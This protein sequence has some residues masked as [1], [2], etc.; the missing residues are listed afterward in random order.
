MPKFEPIS[1][2]SVV[3]PVYNE[4]DN[5]VPL[6]EEIYSVLRGRAFEIVYVDDQSVDDTWLVLNGA[7][8]RFPRL[9]PLRH[10]Q[11][12]GQSTAVRNGVLHARGDWIATLDGDGQNDPADI[13]TLLRERDRASANVGLFAGWRVHRDDHLVRR[14]S[15]RVANAVR[16]WLLDDKTP[17]SGCGIKLFSRQL[18]LELPYFNHMHRFL[19][20][21]VRRTGKQVLSVHVGHRRRTRGVSK[22]GVWNRLWVG[23]VDLAGVAWLIRRGKATEVEQGPA[24]AALDHDAV[25]LAKVGGA[26]SRSQPRSDRSPTAHGPAL[27]SA[28]STRA[29]P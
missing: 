9:R 21:L 25:R 16:G 18:F 26:S 11:Q 27:G 22:Y 10:A 28:L 20:A 7:L 3:V 2:L 4:R 13:L 17:D 15:S 8:A 6:L 19:P 5:I 23:I 12:S 1:L 24:V 14:I 29:G